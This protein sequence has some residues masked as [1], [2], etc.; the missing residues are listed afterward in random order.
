MADILRWNDD[1]LL[2][3]AKLIAYAYVDLLADETRSQISQKVYEWGGATK[4]RNGQLIKE[5]ERRDVV[6]TGALRE[7]QTV[8]LN[9]QGGKITW[10]PPEGYAAKRFRGTGY[11]E[12]GRPADW[13]TPVLDKNPFPAYFIRE[14][15]RAAPIGGGGT[16]T[17]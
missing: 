10:D 4:R 3:K 5:G 7:S 1:Q 17:Y 16:T 2:E 15:Q 12:R 6:D 8:E 9:D 11:G 14:W 13:I